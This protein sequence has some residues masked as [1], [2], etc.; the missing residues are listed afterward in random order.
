[1]R[2]MLGAY[3]SNLIKQFLSEAILLSGLAL[4]LA[5]GM[6]EMLLPLFRN[7]SGTSLSLNYFGNAY[8]LL[9]LLGTALFVGVLAGSYPAF[10]LSG[11]RPAAV[12]QGSFATSASGAALRK[13]L[14]VFQF[15][16]SIALIVGTLVVYRQLEFVRNKNLGITRDQIVVLPYSP[17]AETMSTALRQHPHV[18]NVAVSQ[19]VPVNTTN[20]D[21]RT[22]RVEGS[23]RPFSVHSYVIEE[24]FLAT[25]DL[26][27]VAG[28]SLYKNF[29]EG[30]T[31]FLLNET[32]VRQLGWQSNDEALGKRIRWSGA[33]KSGRV[34]GVVRDF[35]L[36]SLHEQIAPLVLLTIPEDNWWRT[37]ISVRI[38]SADIHGALAFLEST[39]RRLTPGGAFEYF[40]ID[41]SF[42]QLHRDDQRMG[43]LIGCFA[44]ISVFIAC[45]GL[46][47]LASFT[48]QQR[49]KEI[50][51]RKVL[52]ASVAG[53]VKL[54]SKEFAKLV[55]VATAIAWPVAH[56]VMN[57]WLQDYAYRIEIGGSVFVL[58]GG[59]AL[60]IALLTV[61]ALAI[62]AA[63][64]NPVEAL[65]Y[66]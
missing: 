38:E 27:M 15:I 44:T 6:V 25:Y 56:Y 9:T 4:L 49:T 48:A 40:F 19:R 18:K 46:F 26:T 60:L 55:L 3:R 62:R 43:E 24:E 35:H 53:I 29:P 14:V 22:I 30:E 58:A 47:G 45:L 42:A 11:F 13:G 37:F 54:L 8:L 51:I 34:A 61:G 59:V 39:W 5:V 66:E 12:L 64:A 16:I 28:R 32:A 57:K 52:G 33:Y 36:T 10:L 1:M 20:T 41:D 31:P 65:R 2:K 21:T 7:I 50:G 63:L 23:E 17:A